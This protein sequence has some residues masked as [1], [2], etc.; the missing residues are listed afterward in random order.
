MQR[1][2]LSRKNN[3]LQIRRKN[4]KHS[5]QLNYI[6]NHPSYRNVFGVISFMAEVL[7]RLNLN[8]VYLHHKN[9]G[10]ERE[11]IT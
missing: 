5:Y 3:H 7:F 9:L 8:S 11:R 6:P 1:I 10:F 4:N 2:I